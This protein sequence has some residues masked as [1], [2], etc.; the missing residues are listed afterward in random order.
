LVLLS[1]SA[2]LHQ[3]AGVLLVDP[4]IKEGAPLWYGYRNW[5]ATPGINEN[6]PPGPPRDSLYNDLIYW[7][8]RPDA[9]KKAH[10]DNSTSNVHVPVQ[11]LLHL[12][13]A[14]WLTMAEYIKTRL[15]QVEW[16]IS[17]PE[18]FLDTHKDVGDGLKKLHVWGRLV[19][20]YRKMLSETLQQVFHFSCHTTNLIT[21]GSGLGSTSMDSASVG[22]VPS[23]CQCPLHTTPVK[24]GP[25]SAFIDEFICAHS[26][27]EEHQER[28]D[29]L[30]SGL[31]SAVAAVSSARVGQRALDDNKNVA[32]L[33]WLAAFFI[34]CSFIASLF[35]MQADLSQLAETFKFYFK[36]TLP[37]AIIIL[38]LARI[39]ASTR[40]QRFSTRMK[41]RLIRSVIGFINS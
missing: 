3:F 32:R 6:T 16:E 33:T 26:L 21:S 20:L 9:F 36:V 18:H 8:Q 17:S 15:G 38:A 1:S 30:I 37:L 31:T 34:P 39:L 23:T 27:M 41:D 2:D 22:A 11:A 24:E 29:F 7:A 5:E 25:I 28:I 12:V 40:I 14:E 10:S 4:T 13:C 19:P 35:S